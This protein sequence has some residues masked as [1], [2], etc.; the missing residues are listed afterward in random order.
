MISGRRAIIMGEIAAASAMDQWR[1]LHPFRRHMLH[2]KSSAIRPCFPAA[3][4][5]PRH[6]GSCSFL[7]LGSS[8]FLQPGSSFLLQP[9]SGSFLQP[10]SSFIFTRLPPR[11]TSRSSS[12]S[13][14][15]ACYHGRAACY[16]ARSACYFIL[17]F[18]HICL[19][20][21]FYSFFSK[22]PLRIEPAF[23]WRSGS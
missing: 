19:F 21:I 2:R 22:L 5:F 10:G 7:Q 17:F 6:P 15:A 3:I 20:L 9:G 16:F 11:H 1:L 12:D 18:L 4:R 8:F 14:R 13:F 23:V